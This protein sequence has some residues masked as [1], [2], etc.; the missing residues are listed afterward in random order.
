[1]KVLAFLGC[2]DA[3]VVRVA[4]ALGDVTAILIDAAAPDE[5]RLAILRHA[6]VRTVIHLWDAALAARLAPGPERE[7]VYVSLLTTLSRQLDTKTI[8]VGDQP[9]AW[10]GPALAED[11]DLPHV[12]G[13]LDAELQAVEGTGPG[14]DIVVRRLCLQGIARLRGPGQCVLAVLPVESLAAKVA[15]TPAVA[16]KVESWNLQRLGVD[17]GDLPR[18]LLLLGDLATAGVTSGRTFD[19]VRALAD[20]LRQDGLS[21]AP[22][23]QGDVLL[24]DDAQSAEDLIIDGVD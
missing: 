18:P 5:A 3:A 19:D 2:A 1:M 10:L 22:L 15:A 21:P 17:P 14:G 9:L 4:A 20:R 24:E 16:P 11:L 7:P 8:V 12:T 6:G 13:V 23:P